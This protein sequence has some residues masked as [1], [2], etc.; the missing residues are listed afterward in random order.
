MGNTGTKKRLKTQQIMI[1][2]PKDVEEKYLQTIKD[3]I[4]DFNNEKGGEFGIKLQARHW[5]DEI[6]SGVENPQE[7]INKQL[8]VECDYLLAV[9]YLSIGSAN[10]SEDTGTFTEVKYFSDHD[11]QVFLHRYIGEASVDLSSDV[12]CTKI[13]TYLARFK[14][15][16]TQKTFKNY[17][18]EKSLKEGIKNNLTNYFRGIAEKEKREKMKNTPERRKRTTE[19]DNPIQDDMRKHMRTFD[20]WISIGSGEL[21]FSFA[22][23]AEKLISGMQPDGSVKYYIY[24]EGRFRTTP[25]S[26]TLEALYLARLLPDSVRFK[27]QDWVYNS[28]Q[29]TCDDPGEGNDIKGHPAKEEDMPG[30]SWNEGVSVWATSKAL[31]TLIMTGYY[32]REDVF[33]IK[34][35]MQTTYDA[36]SWL[37]DQQYENGGWGFQHMKDYKACEPSVTMTALA[38]KVITKFYIESTKSKNPIKLSRELVK[39]LSSAKKLGIEYLMNTMHEDPEKRHIYWVY[40]NKPSLTG[41]VWV[42]D[43]LNIAQSQEGGELFK[44]RREIVAF[45][46]NKLPANAREYEEYREEVY[47]VGGLTKYKKIPEYHKFYSYLPYHIPVIL[48][49]G[50]KLRKEDHQRIE[51]CIRALTKGSEQFWY[52]ME[53]SDGGFQKPTCFA[54]AM[55]LSVVAFWMRKTWG[56]L[57]VDKL[58][59]AWETEEDDN[60][61]N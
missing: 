3:A 17:V 20:E 34:D 28:R 24:E 22:E 36:L 31:E 33:K 19:N 37:A 4:E 46:I 35:I 14:K 25:T 23:R 54:R 13:E 6:Y 18:D 47:F 49:S 9:F 58:G 55:A 61:E 40:D 8:C 12:D 27:M 15:E 53:S 32:E 56:K 7:T 60:E 51:V 11:K 2:C 41:T 38:L 52:G 16:L 50:V 42:L 39:K 21:K 5:R 1:G 59:G 10:A 57:I 45:C 44:K 48:Q 26:S 43:F 30:W 29:D